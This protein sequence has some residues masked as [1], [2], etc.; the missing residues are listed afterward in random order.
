MAAY[1][2]SHRRACSG[3]QCSSWSDAD[4]DQ[5]SKIGNR[6]SWPQPAFRIQNQLAPTSFQQSDT[7]I[8]KQLATAT[9]AQ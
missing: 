9:A 4:S 5:P 8:I 1:R 7:G 6:E 3:P 2:P